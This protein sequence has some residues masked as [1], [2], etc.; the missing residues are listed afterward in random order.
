MNTGAEA[1]ESAHQGRPRLGL[2][3][4]GRARRAGRDHRRGRQLPRPHHHDHLLLGRPGGARPTS[5]RSRPA[6]SACRTATPRRSRR[7]S[8]T[9]TVAVL[10]E[11]IQGEAGILVP[12]AGYL[13]RGARDHRAR[14]ERALH[15]RRD[16]VGPR[17]HRRDVPVRQRGRRARPL[18][19]RQGAR[20]R[21]RA[22][23]RRS[24]ATRDVL[25][26]LRPASTARPSAATRSPRPS[27]SRSCGMLA[28]GDYQ[29]RA[30]E[31]GARLQAGL[32]RARRPR[33]H[34]GARRRALGRHRHRPRSSAPAA[35]S[36]SG[37]WS[38]ASWRR[39]P[40][41]RP[42]ASRPPIVIEEAD[43]DFLIAEFRSAVG[44]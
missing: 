26:V 4:Q 30:R 14:A 15:R 32:A 43:L 20:R 1:V 17:P 5:A 3:R 9:N 19:A 27:A 31:L 22:G 35:R 25:G 41:A 13:P 28:T 38:A 12:P 29:E 8:T 44:A 33:R 2:P 40:T 10:L 11:P 23:L 6:S 16:P 36:A 7:R 42:S 34:R 24:S 21:H 18:P 37:C 39:T